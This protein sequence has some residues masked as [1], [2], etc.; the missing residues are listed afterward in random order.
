MLI[1]ADA[2]ADVFAKFENGIS[3]F[4]SAF[5][6]AGSGD[7]EPEIQP[8]VLQA[9]ELLRKSKAVA[10]HTK[11]ERP[12][13]SHLQLS[14]RLGPPRQSIADRCFRAYFQH[15]ETT[16]RILH[17]PTFQT[18]YEQYWK[19]T[20]GSAMELRL[21]VLLV[22]AIGSVLLDE[23][24]LDFDFISRTHHWIYT[25]QKWLAGPLEKGQL[26]ISSI[27]LHCLCILARQTLNIGG[28]LIWSSMG[29]LLHMAMQAG[30][31]RDP[32]HLPAMSLLQCEVRRRLW[33]TVLEM[34]VQSALDSE[35]PPM[36]TTSDYDTEAPSNINDDEIDDKS[37]TLITR[38]ENE[39]TSTSE[40]IAMH[41]SFHIRL[42]IVQL[43][44]GLS[45]SIAYEDVLNVSAAF[46]EICGSVYQARTGSVEDFQNTFQANVLEYLCKRF[47]LHLHLPFACRAGTNPLFQYSRKVCADTA[48]LLTTPEQNDMFD[49]FT[50]RAGGPFKHTM[51]YASVAISLE[52]LSQTRRHQANGA[53]HRLAASRSSLKETMYKLLCLTTERIKHG[54]S[55]VKNHVFLSMVLAEVD[56]IERGMPIKNEIACKSLESLEFCHNLLQTQAG[57]STI[58]DFTQLDFA[59][60]DLEQPDLSNAEFD[61]ADFLQYGTLS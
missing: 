50:A 32:K 15:F 22:V 12:T 46:S 6:M 26:S 29:S 35:M 43:L 56:A 23:E 24:D 20:D 37:T 9:T 55:N 27:Q 19:D 10:R 45:S 57:R 47:L 8:L 44:N 59:N 51:R 48:M 7:I 36:I 58:P 34:T 16:Y 13:R 30:L 49:R 31:H 14:E 21:H 54:E 40:Q 52:L 28:D 61:F 60:L 42:Q 5:G 11:L 2:V 33:L 53:I 18:T 4:N 39:S 3:Y 38:P 25:A 17:G 1:T 41:K